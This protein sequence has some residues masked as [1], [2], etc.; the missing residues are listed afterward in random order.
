MGRPGACWCGG[1]KD[2]DFQ[3]KALGGSGSLGLDKQL[4]ESWPCFFLVFWV[5]DFPGLHVPAWGENLGSCSQ[6]LWGFS[7]AAEAE[8]D[9]SAL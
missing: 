6:G 1:G 2:L 3:D 5:N 9:V 8:G 4:V 7:K